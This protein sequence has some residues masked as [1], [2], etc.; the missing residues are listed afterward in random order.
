MA[1]APSEFLV[2][3]DTISHTWTAI[4]VGGSV[5]ITDNELV[6]N[7]RAIALDQADGL[8]AGNRIRDGETGIFTFEGESRAGAPTVTGNDI[9]VSGHGIDF[10][11]GAGRS[12]M[13][14]S[15]PEYPWE[16]ASPSQVQRIGRTI[17]GVRRAVS[18]GFRKGGVMFR[19]IIGLVTGVAIGAAAASVSQGKSGQEIRAEFDRIRAD[20]QQGDFDA[21][22][23]H[24]EERFKELQANLEARFAEVEEMAEEAAEAAEDAADEALRAEEEAKEA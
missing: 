16:T 7:D 9:E 18:T 22:G 20:L 2:E 1:P 19:F 8:I 23:A 21:L 15:V 6:G 17:P 11:S 14:C 12:A 5:T 10:P 13:S 3:G 24:L 4:V